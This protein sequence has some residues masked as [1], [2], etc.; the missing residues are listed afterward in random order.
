VSPGDRGRSGGNDCAAW[1]FV[2]SGAS[3][4]LSLSRGEPAIR[5]APSSHQM[6]V[7]VQAPGT[8]A[9]STTGYLRPHIHLHFC[10]LSTQPY[11]TSLS[12]ILALSGEPPLLYTN[13]S[14]PAHHSS[15]QPCRASTSPTTTAMPPS[16]PK[17]SRYP[18]PPAQE[19][20][21]WAACLMAAL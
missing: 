14:E 10:P 6:H 12:V 5:C 4:S 9:A 8:E 21:L 3:C 2:L 15:Q 16:T 13:P 19:R 17:V 1:S 20:P 11:A 7:H 18:R